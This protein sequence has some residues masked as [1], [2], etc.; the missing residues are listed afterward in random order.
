MKAAPVKKATPAKAA[1]KAAPA[2]ATPAKKAATPRKTAAPKPPTPVAETT[3]PE[4]TKPE[5]TRTE[6]TKPEQTKPE[7]PT[8]TP[9]PPTATPELPIF[10]AVRAAEPRRP[11]PH[12]LLAKL[13]A[14]PAH[15]P[16]TLAH[17]AVRTLGPRARDH[18]A[19][20]RHTYPAATTEGLVRLTIQ[21][22]TRSAGLRGALSAAA[23]P[24]A[25]VA[26]AG[27]AAITHA[28]LVLHLAALHGLDPVD[29][30]RAEDILACAPVAASVR[31]LAGWV[32]LSMIN[33]VLPGAGLVA[34]VLA[35][36]NAIE[37]TAVRARLHYTR[38]Q[39]SQSSGS[40]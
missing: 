39:L 8:A 30:Q 34:T 10:E 35:G 23:G 11:E 38:S 15:A 33:R 32:A 22:F 40:S 27:S 5:P 29:P 24:Y 36:R 2:K 9:E 4:P 12:D 18:V 14:E 13:L 16:A 6:P 3:Q 17:E 25:P 21:R 28:E 37:A 19:A 20:L 26:I 31:I 7:P 1:K